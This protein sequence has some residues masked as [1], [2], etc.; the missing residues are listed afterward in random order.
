MRYLVIEVSPTVKVRLT[1]S[2]VLKY[3]IWSDAPTREAPTCADT[4][5]FPLFVTMTLI[6]DFGILFVLFLYYILIII[7]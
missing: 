5:A 6:V 4:D 7:D 3:S 2:D 1:S